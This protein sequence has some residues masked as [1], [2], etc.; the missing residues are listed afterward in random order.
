MKLI[1]FGGKGGVG[2]TTCS[3]STGLHFARRGLNTL[4]ICTDPA[5]SLAD[6]LGQPLSDEVRKVVGSDNLSALEVSAEKR[7]QQ[8]K[9]EHEKE[10]KKILD[11]TTQLDADD[12]DSVFELPIPGMDE[13]MGFKTIV[14]LIEE[15]RFEMFVV[16]TAPTG[17][18]L[19]LLKSPQ[20]IDDWIKVMAKM[21][22]KYRYV[23]QTFA[24]KYA[25]DN[26]DDF[27]V[28]LK[29]TVKRIEILLKDGKQSEFIVV[30]I[31]EMMAIYE[32]EKLLAELHGFGITVRRLIVNNVLE[33]ES[34]DF[35]RARKQ[36]QQQY[37]EEIR[38]RFGHLEITAVPLQAQPVMG[39]EALERIK[40]F[41]FVPDTATTTFPERTK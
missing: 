4:L 15:D 32:T 21:R 18:A 35:C 1:L 33:S 29:K 16:D 10:I 13:L 3:T 23:V 36:A 9:R 31:P 19:R 41:L 14:D 12:I 6:S 37:L 26:G 2:K 27:L 38:Q 17:H 25:P 5:H 11:T 8:F 24:G 28:S 34:C 40:D 7:L 39:M 22:W 30:T 20:L